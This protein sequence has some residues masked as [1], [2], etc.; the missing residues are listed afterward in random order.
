MKKSILKKALA[1]FLALVM[2]FSM[3]VVSFASEDSEEDIP[4]IVISGMSARYYYNS[5]TGE[6]VLPATFSETLEFFTGTASVSLEALLAGDLSVFSY[7]ISENIFDLLEEFS[8]DENGVPVNE[9]VTTDTYDEP[10]SNYQDY[11]DSCI[12][13]QQALA[14]SIGDE[15][16][17]DKTYYFNYDWRLS[18]LDHADDLNDMIESAK[19]LFGV[20]KVKIVALSMGGTILSSYIYKYGTDSIESMTYAA[21]AYQGVEFAAALVSGNLTLNSSDVLTYFAGLFEDNFIVADSLNGIS[22]ALDSS[23]FTQSAIDSMLDWM[24]E[25]FKD[26]LYEEAI[27]KVFGSMYGVWAL[28]PQDEYEAAKEYML[29]IADL[30]DDFFD[31]ADEYIYEVQANANDMLI[32]A[33]ESGIPVYFVGSYG[34][35]GVAIS[36]ATSYQTDVLIETENMLSDCTVA[37]YGETLGYTDDTNV[38]I[39]TDNII[40]TSNSSFKD[41]TWVIKSTTHVAFRYDS[42]VGDLITWVVTADEPV[43]IYSNELYPQ[44]V[45][46]NA[47]TNTFSSLTQGVVLEG[48]TVEVDDSFFA[49]LIDLIQTIPSTIEDLFSLYILFFK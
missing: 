15:I 45:Q 33:Q 9:Y 46:Y 26:P 41:T 13:F 17:S 38:Y 4:V 30:S 44:F 12:L 6:S 14:R 19:E 40:D 8:C 24:I 21:T 2:G 22:S 36:E 48:D 3:V 39:S 43:D 34:F 25:E 31:K 35:S 42:V 49:K 11:F 29:S 1:S 5:E 18:P 37:M 28:V 10:I 16:G 27:A 20:E 7:G 32:E 23:T 47:L